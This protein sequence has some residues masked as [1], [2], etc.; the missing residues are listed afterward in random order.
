MPFVK[1]FLVKCFYN[2]SFNLCVIFKLV[3]PEPTGP[4]SKTIPSS[5]IEVVNSVVEPLVEKAS[6][7]CS[8]LVKVRRPQLTYKNKEKYL[9]A[10]VPICQLIQLHHVTWPQHKDQQD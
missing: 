7:E 3:L 6:D 10:R 5:C 4:L 9:L 2:N 1:F 8:S